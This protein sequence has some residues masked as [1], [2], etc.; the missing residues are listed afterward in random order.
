[1]LVLVLV[2][3]NITLNSCFLPTPCA[4]LALNIPWG[5]RAI[6]AVPPSGHHSANPAAA[7]PSLVRHLIRSRPGSNHRP[8]FRAPHHIKPLIL[9]FTGHPRRPTAPSLLLP[10]LGRPP[11]LRLASSHSPGLTY[12]SGG[13]RYCSSENGLHCW[14]HAKNTKGDDSACRRP[15]RP[16]SH[17]IPTIPRQETPFRVGRRNRMQLYR[18]AA[19]RTPHAAGEAARDAG[20][21]EVGALAGAHGAIQGNSEHP[22]LSSP[23]VLY[24]KSSRRTREKLG[25]WVFGLPASN[26][27][28]FALPVVGVF[29]NQMGASISVFILPGRGVAM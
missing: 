4:S 2:D 5:A 28:A 10:Y 16:W 18:G 21:G 9:S 17:G 20:L 12:V 19:A 25:W 8:S 29:F 7:S 11:P 22:Q 3:E 27:V 23:M 13:P 14:S 1:M 6:A 15:Y 24:V 26:L